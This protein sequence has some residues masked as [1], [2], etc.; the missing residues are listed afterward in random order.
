[1]PRR[2]EDSIRKAS[3][4]RSFLFVCETEGMVVG[5]KEGR[6]SERFLPYVL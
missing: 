3:A 5:H 2:A 6:K 4:M 1:M